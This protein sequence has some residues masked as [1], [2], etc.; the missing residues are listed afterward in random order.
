MVIQD[1]PVYMDTK[2]TNVQGR[3]FNTSVYRPY[4]L[5]ADVIDFVNWPALY[6][7]QGGSILYKGVAQGRTT[8]DSVRG[9]RPGDLEQ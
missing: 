5:S 2:I 6:V 1:H 3:M 7:C 9:R 4:T 8:S